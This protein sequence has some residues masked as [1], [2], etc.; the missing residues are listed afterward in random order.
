M[1]LLEVAQ[2][3]LT[4]PNPAVPEWTMG[5]FR[6][7]SITFYS[8]ETDTETQVYWLQSGRLCADFRFGLPGQVE[9]G[10]AEATWDGRQM[11]WSQWTALDDRDKWPEPGELRR[12]GNSLIEF[13][14]SGAYVEDWRLQPHEPGMVA[15]L[16]LVDETDEATGQI[17]HSG[18][19]LVVCG[20]HLALIRGGAS[21]TAAYGVRQSDGAV[22]PVLRLDG[23]DPGWSLEG[24]EP[25]PSGLTQTLGCQGRRI[26]RRYTVDT[27]IPHFSFPVATSATDFGQQWLEREAGTVLALSRTV[28]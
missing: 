26:L 18:G 10:V 14:P 15:G 3:Q 17:V 21:F 4:L 12:V 20:Q 25:G 13:A 22:S 5:C 23:N 11:R 16:R 8:G 6:R 19:G 27:L 1:T 28:Y 2:R 24:F 7:R 9:A